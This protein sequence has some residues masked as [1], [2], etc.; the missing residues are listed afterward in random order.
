MWLAGAGLLLTAGGAGWFLWP[1]GQVGKVRALRQELFSE[2]GRALPPDQRRARWEEFRKEQEK[3]TP[4]Q[5]RQLGE[6]MRQQRRAEMTR[7][8]A[9]SPAERQQY[10]DR[11]IDDME[12][13]RQEW[14]QQG[15]GPGRGPGGGPGRGFGPGGPGGAPGGPGGAPGG[16]PPGAPGG[17]TTQER[18]QRRQSFLDGSTPTERGQMMLFMQDM[19]NRRAERG[20]PPMGGRPPR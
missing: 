17:T 7:Y 15:G 5:R 2:A 3:L 14:A 10:L 12:R 18:D 13:R 8:F 11:R 4:E 19:N 16:G 6:D 9:M 20:L 1:D